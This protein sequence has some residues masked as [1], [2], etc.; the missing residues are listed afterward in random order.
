VAQLTTESWGAPTV[1]V[2]HARVLEPSRLPGLIAEDDGEIV[3][4][5]TYYVARHPGP[6]RA[7]LELTL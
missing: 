3:G 6:R 4:L 5:L 2:G 7:E 1:V